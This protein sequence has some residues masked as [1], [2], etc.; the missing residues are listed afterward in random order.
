MRGLDLRA[1]ILKIG[2]HGSDTSTSDAW[3]AAVRPRL[4]VLSCGRQNRHGHPHPR[5]LA[6]L[7]RHGVP[8]FRTDRD[9]AVVVTAEGG[10]LRVRGTLPATLAREE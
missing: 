7:R 10:R 5:T 4:A 6:T 2:H 8:L 3:L 1:D 9:G